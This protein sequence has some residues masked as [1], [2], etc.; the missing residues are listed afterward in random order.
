MAIQPK[1]SASWT[2]MHKSPTQPLHI[3]PTERNAPSGGPCPNCRK[4]KGSPGRAPDS[5]QIDSQSKRKHFGP[6]RR[7]CAMAKSVLASWPAQ[8]HSSPMRVHRRGEPGLI[9][10]FKTPFSHG[11]HRRLLDWN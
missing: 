9:P 1:T 4:N 6:S 7:A 8:G 10:S 5:I 2:E 11:F 3:E